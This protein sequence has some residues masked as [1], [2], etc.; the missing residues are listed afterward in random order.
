M[1]RK[2]SP[3]P[4]DKQNTPGILYRNTNTTGWKFRITVVVV[5]FLMKR[6]LSPPPPTNKILRVYYIGI[7]STR[8][9]D[10]RIKKWRGSYPPPPDKQNTRGMLYRNTN[11]TGWKFRITVVVVF[12][13]MKRKLSPP[14]PTNKILR[15]YYIG[16][17][18]TCT[19]DV[20][21]I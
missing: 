6:K 5:F 15:V 19:E 10:F 21:Y 12:F 4:P 11:T 16:I 14:P 1:K 20:Q 3:P 13:L 18:S 17:P 9:E 8:T 7:P 2:L